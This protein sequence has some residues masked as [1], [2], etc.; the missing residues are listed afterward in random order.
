MFHQYFQM[1]NRLRKHY[2]SLRVLF[3]LV[4]GRFVP[5]IHRKIL[6]SLQYSMLPARRPGITDIWEALNS[7]PAKKP[8]RLQAYGVAPHVTTLNGRRHMN[9]RASR[10]LR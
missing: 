6:Y 8:V 10:G 7:L 2:L 4:T 5:P 9:G 3:C 1:G